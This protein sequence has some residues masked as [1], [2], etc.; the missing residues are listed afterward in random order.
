[1]K[2]PYFVSNPPGIFSTDGVEAEQLLAR[3]GRNTGNLLFISALRKVVRIER[4]SCGVH[5]KPAEVRAEHDGL[6]I[7]AANWLS[8]SSRWGGLARLIEA[9]DL[10]CLMA[11]LGAQSFSFEDKPIVDPGTLRLIKVVAER[12]NSISVRGEY[13]ATVLEHYGIRN[14]TITGCPSLLWSLKPVQI[15]KQNRKIE[16]VAI[17]GTRP[18]D[19]SQVFA[20]HNIYRIG[21]FLSRVAKR[22]GFDYVAQSELPDIRFALGQQLDNEVTYRDDVAF[23]SRIYDDADENRLGGYLHRHARVFFNVED[24]IT[25]LRGKDLTIGTRLHGTIASLLAGTPALLIAH[26]TRTTEMARH[27]DLPCVPAA[28]I[29]K[30][31]DLDVQAIYDS[32]DFGPFNRAQMR[33][34]SRFIDFFE[35][36][37]VEHNLKRVPGTPSLP[38]VQAAAPSV[39]LR[40]SPHAQ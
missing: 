18:N 24:W 27:L 23:L 34:Y 16:H 26:D 22:R 25:Y 9:T 19:A 35:S 38:V 8:S 10:P 6:V 3:T 7:P 31:D 30:G 17:S 15:V 12:S 37:G 39:M 13:T 40:P 20:K 4:F 33:Y 36:N 29:L 5:L 1:V 32:L 11:G 2:N 21:V 14:V 28:D